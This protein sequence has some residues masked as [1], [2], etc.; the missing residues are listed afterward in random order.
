MKTKK[1]WMG[2]TSIEIF[3]MAK[4][5]IRYYL[6]HFAIGHLSGCWYFGGHI[7]HLLETNI[8]A[9]SLFFYEIQQ[10]TSRGRLEKWKRRN[11]QAFDTW[12]KAASRMCWAIKWMIWIPFKL[13]KSLVTLMRPPWRIH[14]E[15]LP[16][17]KVSGLMRTNIQSAIYGN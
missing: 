1:T 16:W 11:D 13:C 3:P 15:T 14:N 10:I 9:S 8:G 6:I 4:E 12:L 5:V 7:W 17:S 2:F